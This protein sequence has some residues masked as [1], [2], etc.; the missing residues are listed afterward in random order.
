VPRRRQTPP[1]VPIRAGILITALT[2]A[3]TPAG[4]QS[5]APAGFLL[6][7]PGL[8]GKSGDSPIF[9]KPTGV[10]RDRDASA[11]GELPLFDDHPAMG[12]GTS[13]FDSVGRR[14]NGKLRQPLSKQQKQ[15]V[16]TAAAAPPANSTAD[17]PP[18]LG[19]RG[20]PGAAVSGVD[21]SFLAPASPDRF[22]RQPARNDN[23]F[24]PLGISA[25]AFLLR[26]AI[27][28]SG[29]YDS[30]PARIQAPRG[31]LVAIVAPEVKVNSNWSRHELTANL[32]G[33]Y[34]AYDTA[35]SLDRPY[36]DG[37]INA[38]IDVTGQTRVDL[39]NRLLV[40][41]D[42]PGSPNIQAGLARLPISTDVGGS[43]GL[44]QRFN[45]FDVALKGGFDRT[46]YQNSTFTDGSSASNDNRNFDRYSTQLRAGYELTPGVKPFVEISADSRI[47]DLS[48]DRSGLDRDS[49]GRAGKLGTSFELTRI[50]TGELAL[51]YLTRSYADPTLQSLKGATVDGSLVWLATALTTFKLTANTS[52]NESTLAGVSGEFTRE[53]GI[54]VDHVFRRWLEASLKFIHDLDVY[55]GS[56]RQDDRY[57]ASA[58]LTYKL[59]RDIQLKGE[60]RRDWL[61]SNI[62][63]NNY[64]AEMVLLSLR[65]QR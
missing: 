64:V 39:E 42:N 63:A 27:E 44:G 13:G 37:K 53:I 38:R 52:A 5:S 15:S 48:V 57:S 16:L 9:R 4:S 18:L 24:D 41:T 36:V 19:Q 40:S 33:T 11:I 46:V 8:D 43:V 54:Q 61:R 6:G 25:G 29:G 56:P 58:S 45:R 14:K 34:T 12:A 22:R 31:S 47:H 60:L 1:G 21:P 59:T 10:A 51:G 49:R 62:P 35:P 26:P 28:L 30:N 2:V 20:A 7:Q 3:I 23:P 55:V 50:L 17:R 32:R 65:L